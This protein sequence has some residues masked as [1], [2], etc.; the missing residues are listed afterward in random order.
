MAAKSVRILFL[1]S[2][3]FVGLEASPA[4][5]RS[6]S[7]VSANGNTATTPTAGNTRELFVRKILDQSPAYGDFPRRPS[8]TP[9]KVGIVGAGISGLYSAIL[10]ESLGIDY[11][12]LEADT[13]LGGRV[14]TY[15]FDEEKWLK[16]KPGEPDYYNYYVCATSA[17]F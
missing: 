1:L 8:T 7:G 16:S 9:L 13:R 6:G 12:I 10:L 15:R 2:W 17:V 4:L 14:F 11:E 3:I 5:R